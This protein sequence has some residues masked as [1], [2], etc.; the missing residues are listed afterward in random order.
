MHGRRLAE[1]DLALALRDGRPDAVFAA[2][3]RARAVSARLAPV[4]PPADPQRAEL[5]GEL[6]LT[7]D[8]L[9]YA[10]A[11]GTEAARLA[12]RRAELER[13]ITERGWTRNGT[14]SARPVAGLDQVRAALNGQ[15]LVVYVESARRLHA[16]TVGESVRGV[17]LGS[18]SEVAELV[19]RVRADLD[20][21][22][23]PLL[24][25]VMRDAVQGSYERSMG[26]L[27]TLLVEPLGLA[28]RSAVITATG[29][30]GQLPWGALPSLRGAPVVVAPSATAW[31]AAARAATRRRFGVAALA[32]GG[33]ARGRQ[34]RGRGRGQA[35]RA[36]S[37]ARP[38]A[39]GP[40]RR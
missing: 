26:A 13:A 36:G 37:G 39:A 1:L 38:T 4:V 40:A 28:G 17:P 31:L 10:E 18:A 33:G 15:E 11:G 25:T 7:I 14:G 16:V 20:V 24:P 12:R 35:R 30:L 27:D 29:V 2:A 5:L 32:G 21:L 19:R 34:P 3:E 23:Q 6:R 22:A 9:R 8:S